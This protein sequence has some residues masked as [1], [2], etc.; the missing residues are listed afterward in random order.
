MRSCLLRAIEEDF[1]RAIRGI[2]AVVGLGIVFIILLLI[3]P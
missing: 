1:W 3:T 2:L